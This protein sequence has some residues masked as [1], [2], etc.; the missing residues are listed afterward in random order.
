MKINHRIRFV[1]GG[2]DT[3]EGELKAVQH[4]KYRE[5]HLCFKANNANIPIARIKLYSRDLFVET[6]AVME[7]AYKLA[8]EIV[9]RFNE[10]PKE[11]KK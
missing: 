9:R 5:V 11:L 2:F 7:D 3:V 4:T 1:E 8:N 6:D 10:F